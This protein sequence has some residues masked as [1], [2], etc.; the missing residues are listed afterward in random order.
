MRRF[1]FLPMVFIL[2]SPSH[3]SALWEFG[4]GARALGMGG[5]FSA[6]SDDPGALAI[7]PAG[8]ANQDGIST[9]LS[10][11]RYFEGLDDGRS[12]GYSF[13]GIVL[14]SLARWGKIGI[15]VEEFNAGDLYNELSL[16]MAIG[17]GKDVGGK[18]NISIGAD[19][20]IRRWNSA[21]VT[22][23]AGEEIEHLKSD[24]VPS[25]DLGLLWGLEGGTS[26]G[27]V[28]GDLGGFD[29]SSAGRGG[30]ERIPFFLRIGFYHEVF[31]FGLS[32]D[33]CI[34]RGIPSIYVGSERWI[35]KDR[36]GF[37]M[38]LAFLDVSQGIDISFG[39]TL[40]P[41]QRPNISL[42]YSCSYPIGT[43]TDAGGIHRVDLSF[44]F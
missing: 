12:I 44:R 23:D 1:S 11:S 33:T 22:T 40:V 5:A 38:G 13:I 43:L 25:F 6:L 21:P 30:R 41:Y 15:S 36:L 20:R 29:I 14:P 17:I 32:L 4:G 24:W 19:V 42:N 18:G 28:L 37:R 39:L 27:F 2:F 9:L 35:A 16:L 34:R 7:N 26:F 8:I 10:N 31:G 3:S